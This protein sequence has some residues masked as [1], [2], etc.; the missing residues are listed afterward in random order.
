M[1]NLDEQI[2]N[3]EKEIRETPYHKATEHHIGRLRA[4]LARLKDRSSETQ[5]G[6]GGGGGGYAVKKQGDATIVFVGPPSVGK[7]TLLNSLTNAESKV[8]PYAFTTVNV[9]PG[10]LVYKDARLQILDVPGLIEGAERGRGRGREVLSVVRGCDLVVFLLDKKYYKDLAE[11]TA[12]LERNGI[13]IDKKRP[14]VRIVKQHDGGITLH[15]NIA[16]DLSRET[17]REIAM[18]CGIRNAEIY[19]NEKVNIDMLIDAFLKN[20]VYIPSLAVINKVD[21]LTEKERARI[22][23]TGEFLFI[24]AEKEIGVGELKEAIW[25]KLGLVRLYL[26]RPDEEPGFDNPIIMKSGDTLSDVSK[27]IGTEF[28]EDKKK[29]KVWGEGAKFPG[30]EVSL[31]TKITEDMQVRFI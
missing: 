16:Q 8:A 27:K 30:Q 14:L 24:S 23:K 28:A 3:I 10:M 31:K 4:K 9:I 20:R 19:I 29:A 13:R 5:T 17:I 1:S 12:M 7:S 21:S 11:I 26:V 2:A 6:K 18:E 25:R 15:S 22:D